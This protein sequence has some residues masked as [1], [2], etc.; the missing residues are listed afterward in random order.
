MADN[1]HSSS[2]IPRIVDAELQLMLSALGAVLVEGPKWCGKTRTSLEAVSSAFYVMDNKELALELPDV[3]LT[4]DTPRLIDEWQL[5]PKLWDRAR[6]HIDDR[7]QPG[8]FI[9]A[10]SSTPRSEKPSHSGTG[11]FAQLKMRTMSLFE[12]GESNGSVS[13]KA[14]FDQTQSSF[15]ESALQDID[16]LVWSLARGGWP[17]SLSL[18]KE[19]VT[20]LPKS[21]LRSIETAD[22]SLP[23]EET[24]AWNAQ[25]ISLLI[26]AIARNV[27]TT[28]G[29]TTL[30]RDVKERAGVLSRKTAA[31]YLNVLKDLFFLEEQPAWSV[32]LRSKAILRQSPKLHLADPSLAVAALDASPEK[33]LQDIWTLGL[34]FESLCYRDVSVYSQALEG[35]I[36]H[37]LDS[38]GLEIDQ[39]VSLHNGKWG[40]IEVKLGDS[41]ID[42]AATQLISFADKVNTDA[43]GEPAFLMI[44][45]A[46][47]YAY[48][49][50]DGVYVVP[51]GCLGP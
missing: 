43:I 16:T 42:K 32:S 6:R 49:R 26:K 45:Y 21:Y 18:P 34:L 23:D 33:L 24:G 8:Q 39:I 9:F 50:G 3:A 10:G 46:G 22:L 35:S 1:T 13:L 40:A 38:D 28:A 11:R 25:K 4:G 7:A 41:Q 48:Q 2:Y 31:L 47:K 37:Y 44:L 12:S 17:A 14:L 19:A 5:A 30:A 51:I 27:S 20:I 15:T 36:Y 29:V